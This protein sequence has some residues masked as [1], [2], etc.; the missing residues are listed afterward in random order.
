MEKPRFRPSSFVEPFDFP[1]WISFL[2]SC[3]TFTLAS[4]LVINHNQVPNLQKLSI[5]DVTLNV[6]GSLLDQPVSNHFSLLQQARF[7]VNW[8]IWILSAATLGQFYKGV[9]FSFLAKTSN[10][11]WPKSLADLTDVSRNYS[12]LTLSD[13]EFNDTYYYSI[14]NLKLSEFVNVSS[15]AKVVNLYENINNR[16]QHFEHFWGWIIFPTFWSAFSKNTPYV[17]STEL[18]NKNLV[19][20]DTS[21]YTSLIS[22]AFY[23]FRT[24]KVV[25]NP[26]VFPLSDVWAIWNVEPTYIY[27]I[28][29]NNLALYF[30]SGLWQKVTRNTE[31]LNKRSYLW[32]LNEFIHFHIADADGKIY[33][34]L[35]SGQLCFL[36][37]Q[38]DS[39][40]QLQTTSTPTMPLTLDILITVFLIY[41]ASL[42][43]CLVLVG[44]EILE[45]N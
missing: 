2:L 18:P 39:G 13:A 4:F 32:N 6:V 36:S 45:I 5:S 1:I 28:F 42:L 41:A 29:T 9:I 12:L 40:S 26:A 35:S 27:H 17:A 16:V 3:F 23:V 33:Q 10:P 20:I 19:V 14:L 22:I 37:Q 15:V 43:V 38:Q 7:P 31:S 11:D 44:I 24:K 25:S 34:T 21:D 30:E 8:K